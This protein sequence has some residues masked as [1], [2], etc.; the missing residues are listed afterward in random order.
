M[1]KVVAFMETLNA[2]LEA[3]AEAV[4][5]SYGI[6]S[7]YKAAGALLGVLL[8]GITIGAGTMTWAS[9]QRD[10]PGRVRSIEFELSEKRAQDEELYKM[11]CEIRATLR[12]LDP[13]SCWRGD[14]EINLP[15]GR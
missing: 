9:F 6:H 7:V 11:V 5:A 4:V 13:L 2:A 15:G 10:L 3:G 1:I 12:G 8:V 14:I